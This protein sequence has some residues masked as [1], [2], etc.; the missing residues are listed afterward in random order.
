MII[1]SVAAAS[2]ILG[3]INNLIKQANET[4]NGVHQVM[5][6]ISDFGEGLTQFEIDRKSSTFK[7]LSQNDLFRITQ[8]RK[9][10]ERYWKDVSDLLAMLDPEMLASF[11]QA[12]AEQESR[13]QE[14][15]RMLALKK[16]QRD[17]LVSQVLVGFTTLIVGG[18]LIGGG[19]W[20]F[21]RVYM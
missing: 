21:I 14:H 11:N 3:S 12:K 10:Q 13:R 4:G 20:I 2:A 9:Q 8:L 6:M 7:Q 15:L 18:V 19:T 5:G 17:R 1:E 16:K